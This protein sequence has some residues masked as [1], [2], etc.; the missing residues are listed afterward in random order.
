MGGEGNFLNVTEQRDFRSRKPRF[1]DFSLKEGGYAFFI[2]SLNTQE[3]GVAVQSIRAA[4]EKGNVA[5]NQFLMAAGKMAFRKMDGVRKLHHLVQ[6]IGARSKTFDDSR[7]LAAAGP[8][9]PKII[10]RGGFTRCFVIFGDANFCGVFFRGKRG[11]FRR[12]FRFFVAHG[13]VTSGRGCRS[14]AL[15]GNSAKPLRTCA[16]E[17]MIYRQ[18]RQHNRAP[19]SRFARTMGGH[20]KEHQRNQRQ[21][22]ARREGITRGEK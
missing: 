12:V 2:G 5:C 13:R 17:E 4:I 22:N 19:Q 10:C 1:R 20:E 14:R 21:K 8:G 7:N 9:A 6:E 18:P 11:G 3:V 16:A 15:R